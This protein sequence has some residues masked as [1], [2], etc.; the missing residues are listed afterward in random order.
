M[1]IAKQEKFFCI[2]KL[3]RNSAKLITQAQQR[4]AVVQGRSL[5][6]IPALV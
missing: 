1:S 3:F 4:E 2:L 5:P 6:P